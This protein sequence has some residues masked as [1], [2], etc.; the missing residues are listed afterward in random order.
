M[1]DKRHLFLTVL[2]IL[3]FAPMGAL[4]GDFHSGLSLVCSDCHIMH[5]SQG[6]GYNANGSGV[7]TPFDPAGHHFL[8]RN[9]V[10]TL[11][12]SCH[13]GQAWAPDVFEAHGNGFVRQ[14]GALNE[15]GGNGL[16]PPTT[17]HT[18]GATDVAPGSS[19]AWNDPDGLNCGNCHAVHGGNSAGYSGYRNLGGHGTAVG[20]SF[21]ISYTRGD[22][23]GSNPLTAWVH[24]NS[25][26]GNSANHYGYTGLAFNEPDQSMSRYAEFCKGCHTNFHGAWGGAEIGGVALTD[27]VGTVLAY[28]EFIRHPAAESNI[29]A[30]GGGHSRLTQFTGHTNQVQVMSPTGQSP[31]NGGYDGTDTELTPSCFS[32]HK[33]HGNQ[34]AFG[35]IFMNGTGTITEEGDGGAYR[36]LCRQCHGQGA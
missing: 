19:P 4:A 22:V 9:D 18:L 28:E 20:S 32:C 12:L 11:C 3:T 36:D 24:E 26:S 31:A 27:S 2:V 8:L 14:G 21:A 7:V 30:I 16:Y 35:L 34:N 25:S 6:H 15:V 29:G 1:L 13:D 17:G 23:E 33:G 5:A 10:N